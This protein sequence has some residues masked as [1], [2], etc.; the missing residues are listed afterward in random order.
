LSSQSPQ[1]EFAV[2]FTITQLCFDLG[3]DDHTSNRRLYDNNNKP[4]Q[5]L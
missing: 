2:W 5:M 3:H 1:H 4:P